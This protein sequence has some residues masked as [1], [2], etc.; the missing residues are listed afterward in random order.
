M[1]IDPTEEVI[2]NFNG[3]KIIRPDPRA[4]LRYDFD[5]RKPGGTWRYINSVDNI[6]KF[7]AQIRTTIEHGGEFRIVEEKTLELIKTNV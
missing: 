4:K 6:E 1:K 3:N 7:D 5:F 2:D